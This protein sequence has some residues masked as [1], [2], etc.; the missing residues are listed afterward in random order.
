VALIN[1]QKKLDISEKLV[2]NLQGWSE[3]DTAAYFQ[4]QEIQNTQKNSRN[5]LVQGDSQDGG[6][7]T[8]VKQTSHNAHE[9]PSFSK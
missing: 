2:V 6:S 3:H 5:E 1:A 4:I 7:A 9:I 8:Y